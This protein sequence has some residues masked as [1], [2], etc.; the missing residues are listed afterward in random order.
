MVT[1]KGLAPLITEIFVRGS[2]YLEDDTA[3]AVRDGLVADFK[4]NKAGKALDGREVS[5]PYKTLNYDFVMTAC[6]QDSGR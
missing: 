5:K 2:N 3:F 6:A 1:G 4:P